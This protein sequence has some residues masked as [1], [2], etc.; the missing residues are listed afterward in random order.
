MA[1]DYSTPA[2][3]IIDDELNLRRSLALILQR[4]GYSVTTAGNGY[5]ARQY[6]KAGAFDLVF[7]DLKMP[8][9][10][11][12][13]LLPEIRRLY[14]AMPVVILTAHATLDTAIAAVRLGARDYLLKP[15]APDRILA[16]VEQ[17]LVES[18]PPRRKRAIMNELLNLVAELH[19]MGEA[20]G[21]GQVGR[22]GPASASSGRYLQR[23][24]FHLDLHTRQVHLS[25]KE[26]SLS[27]TAFEY[28]AALLR[29][30]PDPI[31]YGTLVLEAQGYQPTLM[32]AR[33]LARWRIH[34]LRKAIEADPRQPRYIITVRNTGYRLVT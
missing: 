8:G 21:V 26:I 33:D 27:P 2:I 13:Q 11:G 24:P 6:L 28:L 17:I 30:S 32:E 7:L 15:V 16:R 14:P 5:E 25:E 1:P 19:Q 4:A 12:A 10:D 9:V 31:A 29:H 22:T 23:G 18:A 3:L 34:E 20:N